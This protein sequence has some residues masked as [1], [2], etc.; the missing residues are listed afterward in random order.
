MYT[1]TYMKRERERD[2]ERDRETKREREREG[3]SG[4]GGESEWDFTWVLLYI[5]VCL[6]QLVHNAVQVHLYLFFIITC[7]QHVDNT[8][9]IC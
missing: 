5:H 8:F 1:C 6:L 2:R 9:I 7:I 4:I 3:V